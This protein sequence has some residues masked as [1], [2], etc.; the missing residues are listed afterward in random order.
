MDLQD[1]YNRD[2]SLPIPKVSHPDD[3]MTKPVAASARHSQQELG[4][5][6]KRGSGLWV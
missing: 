5:A 3:Q 4:C 6:L 2:S 1:L